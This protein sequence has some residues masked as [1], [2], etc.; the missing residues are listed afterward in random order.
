MK[1]AESTG[2]GVIQK[3]RGQLLIPKGLSTAGGGGVWT[4]GRSATFDQQVVGVDG[5]AGNELRGAVGPRSEPPWPAG[6]VSAASLAMS[7]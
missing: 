3:A 7:A 5:V 1:A 4:N 6:K 2:A